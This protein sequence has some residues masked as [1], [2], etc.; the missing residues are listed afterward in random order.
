MDWQEEVRKEKEMKTYRR[1]T[2]GDVDYMRQRYKYA[3]VKRI[4]AELGMNVSTVDSAMRRFGIIKP[5]EKTVDPLY[6]EIF[7]HIRAIRKEIDGV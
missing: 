1:W 5:K 7:N 3:P 2:M 4:A 6:L